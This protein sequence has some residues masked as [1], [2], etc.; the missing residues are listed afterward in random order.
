M[1]RARAELLAAP[2]PEAWLFALARNRALS[3]LRRRRR[4][5]ASEREKDLSRSDEGA[6]VR[7]GRR[8]G[9]VLRLASDAGGALDLHDGLGTSRRT[10]LRLRRCPRRR[11]VGLIQRRRE[12]GN[13]SVEH[14]LFA[15]ETA[16]RNSPAAFGAITVKFADG[17]VKPV[18]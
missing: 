8:L 4:S 15:Y 7:C 17:T 2:S 9:R 6:S 14:N 1:F 12:A 10:S 5:I 3:A 13:H 11:R 18:G 16:P